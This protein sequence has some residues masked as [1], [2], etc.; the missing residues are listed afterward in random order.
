MVT[1]GIFGIYLVMRGVVLVVV[2]GNEIHPN[3]RVVKDGLT[4]VSFLIRRL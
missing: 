3:P 2:M 4:T 1:F